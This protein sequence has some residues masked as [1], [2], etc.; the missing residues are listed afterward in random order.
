LEVRGNGGNLLFIAPAI[1][2]GGIW[3]WV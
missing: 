1:T 2:Q 3:F